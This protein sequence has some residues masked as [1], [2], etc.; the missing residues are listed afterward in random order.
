MFDAAE[1]TGRYFQNRGLFSDYY[2]Q[3]RLRDDGAWRDNPAEM[4]GYV[5]D[6]LQNAQTRSAKGHQSG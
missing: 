3:E 5:R 1:C 4:F 6:L 2:L